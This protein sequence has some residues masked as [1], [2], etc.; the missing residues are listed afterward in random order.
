MEQ[1][2]TAL[3]DL[4]AAMHF[5]WFNQML[6]LKISRAVLVTVKHPHL[7]QTPAPDANLKRD[8]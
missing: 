8:G 6:M 2:R 1:G 4:P 3:V 5:C 7:R